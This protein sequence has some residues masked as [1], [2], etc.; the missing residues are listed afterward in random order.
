MPAAGSGSTLGIVLYAAAVMGVFYF[1]WYRP[2]QAQ[3]KKIREMAATLAPGDE[4]MTAGGL[5][6]T[7]RAVDGDVVHVQIADGVVVRFTLRAIIERLSPIED[8]ADD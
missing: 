3:R 8:P 6:G 1:L 5:I 4:V 7:I 2:Q